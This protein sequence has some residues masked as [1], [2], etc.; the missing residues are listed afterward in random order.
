[1]LSPCESTVDIS[2]CKASM[3]R[4]PWTQPATPHRIPVV[5]RSKPALASD[6]N[7]ISSR[8]PCPLLYGCLVSP[9]LPASK[10]LHH[11]P[12]G[13]GG[14]E[15]FTPGYRQYH[16]EYL[17]SPCVIGES[18]RQNQPP[19]LE[20]GQRRLRR[21]STPRPRQPFLEEELRYTTFL[22]GQPFARLAR[23]TPATEFAIL[24]S[25]CSSLDACSQKGS[26]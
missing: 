11:F 9:H 1:M 25:P 20:S 18:E 16:L 10:A 24:N 22:G 14:L 6:T 3:Q 19:I 23:L 13:T 2:S 8:L 4:A 21:T 7:G 26:P 12:N 17:P 5:F 15:S